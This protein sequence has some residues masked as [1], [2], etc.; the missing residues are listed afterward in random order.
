MWIIG[1]KVPFFSTKPTIISKSS[2]PRLLIYIRTHIRRLTV[3]QE[4]AS[5]TEVT[6]TTVGAGIMSSAIPFPATQKK[7]DKG[8]TYGTDK[9]RSYSLYIKHA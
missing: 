8:F 6:V 5:I 9:A 7:D 2:A 4:S 3:A 1:Q